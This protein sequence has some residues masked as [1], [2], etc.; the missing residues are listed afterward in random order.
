MNVHNHRRGDT[1][2][3]NGLSARALELLNFSALG[4]PGPNSTP[5]NVTFNTRYWGRQVRWAWP[6]VHLPRLILPTILPT[7]HMFLA[8]S[9]SCLHSEVLLQSKE[10][11]KVIVMPPKN[12]LLL[13]L[14]A[15]IRAKPYYPMSS[16]T[17]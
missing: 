7:Y 15:H 6:E 17:P 8:L 11:S 1:L 12:P 9:L 2:H 3:W 5:S 10:A 4:N 13:L 14:F 16:A